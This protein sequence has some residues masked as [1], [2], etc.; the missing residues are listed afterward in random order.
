MEN[1]FLAWIKRSFNIVPF[2][3]CS[4]RSTFWVVFFL[5][6][7]TPHLS[8]AQDAIDIHT[9]APRTC[10][11]KET[12]DKC[13]KRLKKK[14]DIRSSKKN[15]NTK[16]I[17][18][19]DEIETE[20]GFVTRRRLPSDEQPLSPFETYVRSLPSEKISMD[21]NQFGYD[22]F[23][24]SPTSFA[25]DH[26]VSVGTDY[27]LGPGDEMIIV[28]W[29][30]MDLKH[31]LVIDAEGKALLPEVGILHLAGRTFAEA[32]A[33]IEKEITRYYRASE[34]KMNI[35]MGNLKSVRIFVVGNALYPGSYTLSA[36]STLVNAIFVSGGPTKT[37]SMRAIEVKRNGKTVVSF[38]LYDFLQK[39][40]KS[41]DIRLLSEDVIFIPPISK[42]AGIAGH[43]KIPAI[44]E[45]KEKTTLTDLVTMAGG[46]T[47]TAFGGRVQIQ[48]V[49]DHQA[50]TLLEQDLMDR[51]ASDLALEDGD[52]V[53]I[54]PVI[55][56]KEVVHIS[57]AIGSPGAFGVTPGITTVKS[58]IAQSGGTAP[59]ALEEAEISRTTIT[60]SGP[61]TQKI[62]IN[63]KKAME[64]DPNH[65]IA[66]QNNDY[67][68]V[69]SVPEWQPYKMVTIRGKVQFP[70][71]YLIQKGETM[72]SL[73]E[74]A[75][76]VTHDAYLEGAIFT[77]ESVRALQN[78]SLTER[79]DRLEK[80]LLLGVGSGME[81]AVSG[82]S[83]A[84]EKSA[85]EQRKEL[86]AK[87]K[88]AQPL[89][90]INLKLAP[91]DRLAGSPS[92]IV[93]EDGDSLF[94][95][96]R[97]VSVA[98]LGSI[99]NPG[100]HLYAKKTSLSDYIE[101]SGGMDKDADHDEIYVLKVDG[102]AISRRI[103]GGS[104]F[105]GGFMGM[106][107]APGDTVIIPE[108]INRTP[109]LREVKDITQILYQIAVAA[110]V[111]I[112]LP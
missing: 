41:K 76:G 24:E 26:A 54:F 96:E 86:I 5:L 77:R 55:E 74:R 11:D 81:T 69:K 78:K 34:I 88:S 94:I 67:L 2:S 90:R 37:G 105:T 53:R 112:K 20:E 43:I 13:I 25:P 91:I 45:L 83:A 30:K 4:G 42:M 66:L 99:Y 60:Q 19:E 47:A 108:T 46:L 50:I 28:I 10:K 22:L 98:V 63:I 15:K 85:L 97:P 87:L 3:I 56:K 64:G 110:A 82:E 80:R 95:P 79:I 84:L 7:L 75:G 101:M 104:F 52:I 29:G 18:S 107:L 61:T 40:D 72:A 58:V 57:G 92:D 70:E 103:G 16:N 31:T 106:G 62:K 21:I 1:H 27:L 68:F 71:K 36:F 8:I 14:G 44:Y 39:G 6:A 35:S 48:R 65:N 89:G 73:I 100:S 33:D 23:D 9:T 51:A 93:L 32:K 17:E 12:I 59:H 102:T 109:W 111:I 49:K 38:D